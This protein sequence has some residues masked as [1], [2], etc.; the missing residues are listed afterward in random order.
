MSTETYANL[1]E[2]SVD[3]N[4]SVINVIAEL[5][6]FTNQLVTINDGPTEKE[7]IELYKKVQLSGYSVDRL[8]DY[9]RKLFRIV[10]NLR[11]TYCKHDRIV[12]DNN[13]DIAH[14]CYVCSKCGIIM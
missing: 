13:F 3:L 4:N 2:E 14:T 12:D 8:H 6:T 7:V 11:G 1:I 10:D 5:K 9:H